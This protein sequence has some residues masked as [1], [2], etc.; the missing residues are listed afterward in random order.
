MLV[1][2]NLI[3]KISQVEHCF[4]NASDHATISIEIAMDIDKQ[5]QGIF[6][7]PP[8]IQNDPIY[9]KIAKE[10][11]IDTQLKCKKDVDMVKTYKELIK[12]LRYDKTFIKIFMTWNNLH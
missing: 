2:P 4:T 1:T 7:A 11:I 5:G 12:K 9:V 10:L 8:Y 3:D 6:R